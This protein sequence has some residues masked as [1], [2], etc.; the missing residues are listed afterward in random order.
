L[1]VSVLAQFKVWLQYCFLSAL[2]PISANAEIIGEETLEISKNRN[3]HRSNFPSGQQRKTKGKGLTKVVPSMGSGSN[4]QPSA[5]SSSSNSSPLEEK[6]QTPSSTRSTTHVIVK[7]KTKADL[8]R[9]PEGES[10][11]PSTNHSSHKESASEESSK[12]QSKG[13]KSSQKLK[14]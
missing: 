12:E 5:N 10:H 8:P 2:P 3:N 1:V 6:P 4:S 13:S 11:A 7:A 14:D 9:I